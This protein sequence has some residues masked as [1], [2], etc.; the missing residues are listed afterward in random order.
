VAGILMYEMLYGCTP[1]RGQT[2][3]KTFTNVLHKDLVFPKGTPMSL[4]ARQ[5]M[6][7]L[8]Q[9]DPNQR[10]GSQFG[11]HDLKQ[12]GFFRDINWPLIRNMVPPSLDILRDLTTR[13]DELAHN[14]TKDLD[15][16]EDI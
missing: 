3:Q 11:A 2:R 15:W 8:L 1:F 7:A 13:E 16:E 5:L 9:R 12:H 6:W 14:T 4:E 10:L